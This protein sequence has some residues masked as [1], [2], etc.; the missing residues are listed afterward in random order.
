MLVH[1]ERGDV[2]GLRGSTARFIYRKLCSE[3]CREPETARGED[4]S[5]GNGQ[6]RR[7]KEGKSAQVAGLL[8]PGIV[9]TS[10][11]G[12]DMSIGTVIAADRVPQRSMRCTMP[13]RCAP[14]LCV[15]EAWP[16]TKHAQMVNGAW[17]V[18]LPLAPILW[19][20]PAGWRYVSGL[21]FKRPLTL[22]LT[23]MTCM[24]WR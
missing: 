8:R 9:G 5:D 4:R 6:R 12:G 10:D 13:L 18:P 24:C 11:R 15:P 21:E 3:N 20:G 14:P 2:E 17:S 22:L 19:L 7:S 16:E 1:V 23:H